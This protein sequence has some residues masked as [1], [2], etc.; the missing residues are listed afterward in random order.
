MKTVLLRSSK[1]FGK[2]RVSIFGTGNGIGGGLIMVKVKVKEK[3]K[4][5]EI[6]E[7]QGNVV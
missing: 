3:E 6:E 1:A 4:G 7:D 5:G 2:D